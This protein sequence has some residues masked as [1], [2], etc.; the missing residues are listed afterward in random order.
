M[1]RLLVAALLFAFSASAAPEKWWDAYNRGVAAVN[2]RN[3]K[4]AA[5]SLQKS[6]DEMPNEGTNVRAKDKLI[7]YVPHFWLGI[8]KLNLGDP[9][10][11]LREW[12]ICED[13]GVLQRTEYYASM[14]DWMVRAQ[15]EKLRLAQNAAAGPKKA[16]GTA[17]AK[18]VNM[19]LEAMKQGGD[20]TESYASANRKYQDANAQFQKAGTD[21][22]AYKAV[23]QAAQQAAALFGTAAEEGKK[24]KLARTTA[25][26]QKKVVAP[27]VQAAVVV[28]APAPVK[29]A[30]TA[31]PPV[32]KK[33]TPA[34]MT[35]VMSSAEV[36]KLLA[37]R[38][39][40]LK[41]NVPPQ[42]K[43]EQKVAAA[44][45]L[46]SAPNTPAPAAAV[47]VDL[48]PAYRLFAKG[49]ISGSER[50]LDVIVRAHGVAEAYL[51]RGC[52]R[53]TRA[54]LSRDRDALLLKAQDDFRAAL[55]RNR[56]LRLD[57]AVFSPK[58]VEYFDKVRRKRR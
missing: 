39:A 8:A 27:P 34:E 7:T 51:L 40:K 36:D 52:A 11:A 19:Q 25:P 57:R 2:A 37:E 58:L 4:V 24:L 10:G 20:R 35:P 29:V 15:A 22:N 50:Q 5:D 43:S 56:N 46:P 33:E 45:E 44:P 54:M 14:K 41:K 6:I 9:D 31:P 12:R 26:A 21:I 49:D 13:Q 17:L 1:K 28:P 38:D 16:A 42:K 30:E 47:K 23:E 18:A 55:D 32:A 53:W 3:Y 48:R